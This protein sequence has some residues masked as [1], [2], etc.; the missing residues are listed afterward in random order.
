MKLDV[1]QVSSNHPILNSILEWL[2]D[3]T[4]LEFTITSPHRTGPGTHG[5]MPTRA[6]DLRIR[7]KDI[8]EAIE[9]FI[10]RHWQYD[11]TRKHFMCCKLHGEDSNMH[12]HIQVHERTVKL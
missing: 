1:K 10:N 6:H 11:P 9:I 12:L 7:N 2:E 5:T 4:G 8:G 3:E